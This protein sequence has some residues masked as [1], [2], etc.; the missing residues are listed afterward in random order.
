[1]ATVWSLGLLA[2]KWQEKIQ[3]QFVYKIMV[4]GF[5]I[6]LIFAHA[7]GTY[8]RN[9]VWATGETLW[10]DA[11]QKS[12]NNGRALMNYGLSKMKISDYPAALDCFERA[13]KI[14]PK[15]SYL[16]INM[17]VLKGAMG[18][19]AEAEVNFKQA[20]L[21]NP[22]NPEC[23]YYY[24]TWLRAQG[25]FKEALQLAKDGLNT[26]PGHAG[27]KSLY[28]DL[29]AL[30]A[31]EGNQLQL[32][33]QTAKEKPSVNNYI[34]LSLLYYQNQQYEKCMDASNEAIKLKPDCVEAYNNICSAQNILGNYDAAIKIGQQ[35]LKIDPNYQLVKNNVADGLARKEKVEAALALIRKEASEANYINLSLVY[36]NL[37]SFQR[38]ADAAE[39]ALKMNPNSVAACNNSCSAYNMLKLWDK[40]ITAGEKGL[41]I[42]PSNQLMKNNL[43]VSKKGKLGN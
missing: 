20:I 26:S 32:A 22:G 43:E 23:Y 13:L 21:L 36:Y 11:V 6:A 8:Q 9:K 25:R 5:P 2:M 42:D 39:L 24:G 3:Q 40:A 10:A 30:A 4:I 18:A 41:K 27:N 19:P 7:Y 12:P 33:E 31:N 38:C 28:T 1:M 34:A 29:M 15:Y 35:A 37:G 14:I 17:G 16:Y